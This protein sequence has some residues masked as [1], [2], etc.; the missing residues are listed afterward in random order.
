[1]GSIVY[2]CDNKENII[3]N[4]DIYISFNSNREEENNHK[5]DNFIKLIKKKY[6]KEY[7][8]LLKDYIKINVNEKKSENEI[9]NLTNNPIN[10]NNNY[11]E[12]NNNI[13][14]E[15]NNKEI[16]NKKENNKNEKDNK[17]QYDL[18]S[19][20]CNLTL[21]SSSNLKSI[22]NNESD[23]Q[24]NINDNNIKNNQNQNQETPNPSY[25]SQSSSILKNASSANESNMTNITKKAKKKSQKKVKK[26]I[27]E[28]LTPIPEYPTPSGNYDKSKMPGDL[29][30]NFNDIP[31][32]DEIIKVE[33]DIGEFIVEQKELLKY[34]EQYPY[35][36]KNFSIRYPNGEKYSGYF[37]PD[38][39]KEVFGIQINK[40]GSKY[41]GF[42]KNGMFEGR[43]RLILRKG[44]Y[45]EGEFKQNKANG[46]G[47][48]VNIK[49]EIY[50]GN[51][52]DD[53][54]EGDGELILKDGSRYN[55]QFKKGLKNGKGKISWTDSSYYEGDFANNYFDGYGVYMMRNKKVYIGE[56]KNGQMNGLGIFSCPD[57]KCYKGYYE[58]D[59]KNGFG[60]Y[61][62][63]NN[64]KY[65]GKFKKGKQYGIGRVTNEKGEKQLGLYLKGKRLKYL[66]EKDF[67][68][69]ISNI[70]KEIEKIN[71]IINNNEFFVKNIGL[72]TIIQEKYF[73]PE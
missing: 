72:L 40:D 32:N 20:N 54:Q 53:K 31:L 18:Q 7:F 39:E 33:N 49:G 15:N 62:G 42:F 27:C 12:I 1:M 17:K 70:D 61:S 19:N 46:F 43:G 58:N 65:E 26:N 51:W 59:K 44:D 71:Y 63:K 34:M 66:N 3:I 55:G 38:W 57:G 29:I 8:E 56:W 22:N 14:Q 2:S 16:L 73:M 60:I 11:N 5:I 35:V 69:D 10:I 50:I 68:E 37:S 45:F 47:K 36:P 21:N 23:S 30:F 9:I 25:Q 24:I 67:K 28:M 41:I 6:T 52:V 13:T 48:Y 64:L 4:Q